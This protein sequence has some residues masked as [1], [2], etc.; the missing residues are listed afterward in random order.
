M[1]KNFI[2][3]L[4]VII[5]TVVFILFFYF[6]I[7]WNYLI[8]NNKIMPIYSEHVANMYVN[9]GALSREKQI[10]RLFFDYWVSVFRF[11]SLSANLILFSDIFEKIKIILSK[12]NTDTNFILK[13]ILFLILAIFTIYILVLFAYQL[14]IFIRAIYALYD[15]YWMNKS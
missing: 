11:L 14:K 2:K 7:R 1:K 13:I 5:M 9:F 15:I 10:S 12:K 3:Y 6:N 4:K 8:I